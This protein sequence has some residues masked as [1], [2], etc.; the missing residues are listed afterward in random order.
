MPAL[1]RGLSPFSDSSRKGVDS[2]TVRHMQRLTTIRLLFTV[3]EVRLS[4]MLSSLS[5]L[6]LMGQHKSKE[7]QATCILTVERLY[8]SSIMT[9]SVAI[10]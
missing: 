1:Q 9:L 2:D 7:P 10:N 8:R 4:H 5:H 3:R 6:K